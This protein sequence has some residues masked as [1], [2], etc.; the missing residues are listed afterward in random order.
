MTI[1]D[2]GGREN[3][4][5]N[6]EQWRTASKCTTESDHECLTDGK[7]PKEH[8]IQRVLF[9]VNEHG[10]EHCNQKTAKP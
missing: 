2:L 4:E 7:S 6:D 5:D 9:A 3:R 1:L 8:E 10:K